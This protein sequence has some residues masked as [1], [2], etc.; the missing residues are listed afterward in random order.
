M[1]M[2]SS[3]MGLKMNDKRLQL[4]PLCRHETAENKSAQE[5]MLLVS[6]NGVWH[7]RESTPHMFKIIDFHSSVINWF[8][9]WIM[10]EFIMIFTSTH[11][12]LVMQYSIF[13]MITILVV[14]NNHLP[15]MWHCSNYCEMW[16][17]LFQS[18]LV[19][20]CKLSLDNYSCT[21]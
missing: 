11:C 16:L 1:A 17:S 13:L 18:L 15:N 8:Y 9:A 12:S 6:M 14:H 7:H 5:V 10:N 21:Q 4:E 2:L 19:L 3:A 20:N